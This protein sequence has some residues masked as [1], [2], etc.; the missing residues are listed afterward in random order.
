[1]FVSHVSLRIL[2]WVNHHF[3]TIIW[4]FDFFSNH[5]TSNLSWLVP[6]P[7]GCFNENHLLEWVQLFV[8]EVFPVEL[9][10]FCCANLHIH[11]FKTTMRSHFLGHQIGEMH[12]RSLG[13][14]ISKWVFQNFV[15]HGLFT[16]RC[17]FF[18]D[19]GPFYFLG[20]F[21]ILN[22]PGT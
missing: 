15:K 7:V 10:S 3:S 13:V 6:F 11:I 17:F 5:L 19:F 12:F 21:H 16:A 22:T 14:C 2:P 8:V 4:G 18:N 20:W 1:M 9:L